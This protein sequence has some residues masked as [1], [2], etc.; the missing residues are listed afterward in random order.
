MPL[1]TVYPEF[2]SLGLLLRDKHYHQQTGTNGFGACPAMTPRFSWIKRMSHFWQ[3]HYN[4][5]AWIADCD[6]KLITY[7]AY[8]IQS[9]KSLSVL[10]P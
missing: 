3:I 6:N 8:K 5:S 10:I 7:H 2:F 9:A 1:V 4:Y